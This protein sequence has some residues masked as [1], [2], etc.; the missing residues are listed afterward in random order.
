MVELNLQIP[1]P[2]DGEENAT[3]KQKDFIQALLREV[4]GGAFPQETLDDL[5]KW[6][7]SSIIDQ[8]QSFKKEL[9]GDK[10]LVVIS[11]YGSLL[12]L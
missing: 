7:A 2:Q 9:S 10:P 4:G 1:E 11:F 8:L 3:S 6:Q 5:G 12:Y